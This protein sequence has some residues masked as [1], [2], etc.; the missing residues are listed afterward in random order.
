MFQPQFDQE[1]TDKAMSKVVERIKKV[2]YNVV[3]PASERSARH[4]KAIDRKAAHDSKRCQ[5]C[6]EG[7][8][9]ESRDGEYG[10][11]GYHNANSRFEIEREFRFQNGTKH[12]IDWRLKVDG[13]VSRQKSE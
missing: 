11:G 3:P 7:V 4:S 2:F 10:F 1:A 12:K 9:I 5:A 8:C 13:K 6:R